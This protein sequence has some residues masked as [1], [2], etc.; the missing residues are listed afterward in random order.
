MKRLLAVLLGTTLFS[1]AVLGCCWHHAH[2]YAPRLAQSN[3]GTHSKAGERHVCPC[4]RAPVQ[5]QQDSDKD[6]G[7]C[8]VEQECAGVCIY[9]PVEKTCLDDVLIGAFLWAVL[10]TQTLDE[11]P[12]EHRS[13]GRALY[14][15]ADH[16]VPLHLLHQVMLI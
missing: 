5:P 10:P 4:H 12:V 6:S 1:H 3:G 14:A 7:G 15:P 9:L 8:P 11:R 16:S 2:T 13:V